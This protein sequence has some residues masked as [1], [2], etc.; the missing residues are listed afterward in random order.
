MSR[1]ALSDRALCQ[2]EDVERLVPGFEFDEPTEDAIID[3]INQQSEDVQIAT[4]REITPIQTG[5]TERL[6]DL[7][8]RQVALR[9]VSIGDCSTV[10]AVQIRDQDG[11]VQETVTQPAYVL[12]PRVRQ[13]WEPI[14]QIWFPA[15]GVPTPVSALLCGRVV[16]VTG[17]WGFPSI[18]DAIRGATAK[19]VLVRYASHPA[20]AGTE[21]ADALVDLN[22]AAMFAAASDTI[23]RF[24]QAL[25]A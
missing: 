21:L 1:V 23:D 18:P 10:T 8:D 11:T 4:G 16:A 14:R 22:L 5:V 19:L 7:D 9:R 12:L 13:Q 3:L 6:F 17:T 24:G 15:I 20:S 25:I 2:P